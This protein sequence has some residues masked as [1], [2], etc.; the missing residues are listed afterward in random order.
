MRRWLERIHAIILETVVPVFAVENAL[1]EARGLIPSL[2][3]EEA[4]SEKLFH[5][6]AF[7]FRFLVDFQRRL[8]IFEEIG[9]CAEAKMLGFLMFTST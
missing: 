9:R 7:S 6:L 4:R 5:V 3:V 1:A 8:T 2:V